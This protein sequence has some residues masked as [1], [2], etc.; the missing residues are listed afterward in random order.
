MDLK[1]RK[2]PKSGRREKDDHKIRKTR[3]QL[4]VNNEDNKERPL[5][6]F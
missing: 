3:R 2:V 5:T 4:K 1:G 6:S